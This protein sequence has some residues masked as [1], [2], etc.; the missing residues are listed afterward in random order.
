MERSIASIDVGT[1]KI[2]TLVGEVSELG[3]L[4]IVGVGVSPS[5]GL[6]KGVVVNATE[7]AD[8]IVSSVDRAERISGYQV[9]R[10]YVGIA[11]QH[12]ASRNSR[13]VVAIPRGDQGIVDD[14]VARALDASQAIS[15][16]DHH[17]VLHVVPRGFSIDG[18]EGV[19][20]PRGMYGARLEVEAHLVTGSTP[21]V[22][23]LVKCI[24]SLNIELDELIVAPLA[25]GEAV[26]TDTERAMGVALADI[27]GGTTDIAIFI[28][29][30]V[31]HTAIL[32]VGGNHLTND[33][34]I[35]L[36]T[37]FEEAEELKRTWGHACPDQVPADRELDIAA[38]GEEPHQKITQRQLAEVLHARVTEIASMILQEIKRSGYDG[39][40][41]AGVVLCGGTAEL[42]G[43]SEVVRQVVGLPVR[44]GSPHNLEGLVDTL[45]RPAYATGVGLLTWE[46]NH[47][48][49]V[50]PRPVRPSLGSRVAQWF[51]VFLP[52]QG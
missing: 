40:L 8:A 3:V 38:F 44:I 20:D 2:C 51:R 52:D 45:T 48:S 32:P 13:G 43:I 16:P 25:S 39:L 27:G 41:P 15:I 26:L 24:H 22:Q 19:S 35:C 17:E 36:R 47:K 23:N 34:A 11:G 7:A 46:Q 6:R 37:P 1:T 18:Q 29:G 10:A 49:T 30:S 5:R 9:T 31:W 42:P 33:V 14:D 28:E 50:R 4:R 12:I 21:A